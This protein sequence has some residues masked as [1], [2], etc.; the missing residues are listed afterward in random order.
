M[1]SAYVPVEP[2][3]VAAAWSAICDWMSANAGTVA[4]LISAIAAILAIWV[5]VRIQ[6][7]NT[8]P[9][10]IAYIEMEG[11]IDLKLVLKNIGQGAAYNVKIENFD[12]GMVQA[13]ESSFIKIVGGSFVA[14]GCPMLA[15]GCVRETILA[16]TTYA[17]AN[18][19]GKDNAITVS[20]SLKPDDPRRQLNN[21]TL[22]YDSFLNSL[23]TDSLDLRAVKALEGIQRKLENRPA[24]P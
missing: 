22:E 19:K 9:N 17:L 4:S 2:F 7:E 24:M 10:V 13:G 5:A 12:I 3:D 16:S 23:H 14:N 6:R 20:W 8:S 21:C 1:G 18:L 11:S 15:P